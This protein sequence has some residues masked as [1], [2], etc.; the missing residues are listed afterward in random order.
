MDKK[1]YDDFLNILKEE[2][3]PAMGC[4]EPIAIAYAAALAKNAL[5]QLPERL[6]I[7]VSGNIL[8]NVKSVIVP[9]TGGLKGVIAAAAAG[10]VAGRHDRKLE[11]LSGLTQSDIREI[12]AYLSRVEACVKAADSGC[13]FDIGIRVFAGSEQAYARIEGH[14]TNVVE[15]S[16]NGEKLVH[17]TVE[18][19]HA[20][21]GMTDRTQLTV[22]RIIEFADNAD[23]S[24]LEPLIARQIDYNSA[25][26]KEGLTGDCGARVGKVLIDSYGNGVHNLARATAAAGSDA[27]MNGC[28]LPVV[29][30]SGSGNQGMTAS[31]P[32]VVYA[33]HLNSPREKLI[34]A[35]ALSDLLT[36]HL[37]TGIGRLS[38]YC[39]AVSAGAGAGAGV[40]YLNGGGFEEI[41]HTLVNA[42]AITSGLI[43]DGAKSSCAAK[44]AS[45][46]DAGLLGYEMYRR[47]SQF[48][49]GDG[50]L[51]N[52]VENT[53]DNVCDLA[54]VGMKETDEEI[55]RLMIKDLA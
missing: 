7:T 20:D 9:C 54:R 49:G 17:K 32:V 13:V 44:I 41:A 10:V 45:A 16:R 40:A 43:C 5:G 51:R 52:G 24:L 36:I 33:R 55:I 25:I 1:L 4:T 53:I 2:L 6:E 19:E 23:L 15:V 28:S 50:I 27:R 38:A 12:K 3:L 39:G 11:V 47:G 30:V 35:V 29:I 14:H 48:Y 18:R 34:R 46:V 42:L 8:K 22:K 26:A 21:D 37:K 31:L